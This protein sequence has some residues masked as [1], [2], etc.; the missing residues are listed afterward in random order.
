LT[1][2]PETPDASETSASIER[3]AV[4]DDVGLVSWR[5]QDLAECRG[6]GCALSFVAEL[7]M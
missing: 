3:E 6:H 1:A 2:V 5:E 7:V 4:V